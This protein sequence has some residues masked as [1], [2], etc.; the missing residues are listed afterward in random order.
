M[1][2]EKSLPFGEGLLSLPQLF[3]GVHEFDLE[4][5]DPKEQDRQ[6]RR[7]IDFVET[8]KGFFPSLKVEPTLAFI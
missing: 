5:G 4:V 7:E 6:V 8:A 1:V 3:V 2:L